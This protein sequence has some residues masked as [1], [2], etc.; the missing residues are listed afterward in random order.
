M[1]RQPQIVPIGVAPT[2]EGSQVDPNLARKRNRDTSQQLTQLYNPS[3]VVVPH[4]PNYQ[5]PR[6]LAHLNQSTKPSLL[7]QQTV[8]KLGV[9]SE[10][11][12]SDSIQSV[13]QPRN[14]LQ[15]PDMSRFQNSM[16]NQKNFNSADT[17]SS[18]SKDINVESLKRSR[19]S[20]LR[21][22]RNDDVSETSPQPKK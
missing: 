1:Q 22:P 20:P 16:A 19:A 14:R 3:R 13:P 10:S 8:S 9:R 11:S 6:N 5:H 21:S 7:N 17:R 4:Q 2:R 12:A 15:Q 18:N